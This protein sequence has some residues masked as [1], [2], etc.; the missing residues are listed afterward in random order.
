MKHVTLLLAFSAFVCVAQGQPTPSP[1]KKTPGGGATPKRAADGMPLY[2]QTELPAT[3]FASGYA[4]GR[5]MVAQDTGG[6]IKGAVRGDVFFGPGAEAE[7]LAGT[8]KGHG[9]YA[10]L[11]PNAIAR[12][13]Q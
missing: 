5:L 13:L 6:A 2:L 12:Q 3:R 11:V 4:F 10:V 9:V 8:M 7:A 1:I